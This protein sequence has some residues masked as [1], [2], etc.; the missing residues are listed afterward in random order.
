MNNNA[1]TVT[2][3]TYD[4]RGNITK[5][6]IGSQ[7]I[8]Y[9]YDDLGQLVREDNEV[10]N[11]TCVY[12]YDNAGN[13]TAKRTYALTASD[14]TP[15]SP[16]S[17]GSYTYGDSAWGDKLTA[18][19]GVTI[20]YDEIG[21]P[22]SYYNGFSFT[23]TG[24]SLTGATRGVNTLSFT[25]N[26]EGIRTS[27]TV[28]GV[29][30][31]YYLNGSNIIAEVTDSYTIIYIY[32]EN[33]TPLGMQ[34]REPTYA[35][36]VWD[37]FWYEKNLQGDI[38]AVYN[39]SGTK[40]VAY[41]YDA[42]GNHTVTYYN[43]GS[44]IAA[45]KNPFRYRGYY[46]DTDLGLYY[47]NSRYY[48]SNTG[49]FISPDNADVIVATPMGL[50]DKNLY[51]YCDNNPVVRVDH[52]GRFWDTV[53]DVISLGAGIVEVSINP[54][55]I[56][57]WVGLVGDVV[58]LIPFVSGVGEATDLIRVATKVDDIVDAVDNVYD[59]AKGIH[60]ITNAMDATSGGIKY[61]DKVLKQMS[62]ASDLK[63]SFPIMIDSFVDLNNASHLIG[64]DN[65]IRYL[66]QIPGKI[67]H[68]SGVFEYIIDFDGW[69]NH[70]FFKE[71][72]R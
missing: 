35:E 26:D 20:T 32:D 58:D 42:W 43:G 56:W 72:K 33:G 28:N 57:A 65:I 46:Y 68:R 47:L 11:K 40:L 64:G 60:N 49:R 12:T 5:I 6:V 19:N 62:N 3:Y 8:R 21:N 25:Y 69:C 45:I 2:E 59:T 52:G 70:R 51:A 4:A 24:R 34:Y 54:G 23:W 14:V 18:Y 53:F 30:H 55:D 13:I 39:A 48:D 36:G 29:T 16:T 38:V 1:A 67:N 50:T 17:T 15:T 10:L 31:K 37:V 66:V 27:K 9:V 61:T 71:F 44:A 63:H 41:T 22:L 7:E